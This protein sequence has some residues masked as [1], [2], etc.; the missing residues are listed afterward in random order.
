MDEQEKILAEYLITNKRNLKFDYIDD[1]NQDNMYEVIYNDNIIGI[2]NII[3]DTGIINV[4]DIKA[5]WLHIYNN[6]DKVKDTYFDLNKLKE[7]F[8]NKLFNDPLFTARTK[9]IDSV[10]KLFELLDI[11]YNNESLKVY[12]FPAVANFNEIAKDYTNNTDSN[13][14]KY[15]GFLITQI[16]G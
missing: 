12:L 1:T 6:I 3:K 4:D 11:R 14:I 2:Y 9:N 16:E 7:Y 8:G 10:K 15:K 13:S 5:D